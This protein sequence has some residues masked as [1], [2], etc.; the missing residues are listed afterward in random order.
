MKQEVSEEDILLIINHS[1]ERRMIIHFIIFYNS[2]KWPLSY[3]YIQYN[4]YFDMVVGLRR[5]QWHPTL[6]LLPGKSHGWRSL[7]GHSP[8]GH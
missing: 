5:R 2:L 8:W 7:V 6:A 4:E 1:L 3:H